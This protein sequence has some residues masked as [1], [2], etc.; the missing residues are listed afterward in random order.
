MI[1]STWDWN[2]WNGSRKGK[3]I[4]FRHPHAPPP[5]SPPLQLKFRR[6]ISYVLARPR[7]GYDLS[8]YISLEITKADSFTLTRPTYIFREPQTG[9][10]EESIR[11]NFF[12][13]SRQDHYDREIWSIF[14][15]FQNR[16]GSS[17]ANLLSRSCFVAS[18]NVNEEIVDE[19]QF[20]RRKRKESLREFFESKAKFRIHQ[21]YVKAL[22]VPLN[23]C[24]VLFIGGGRV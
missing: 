6:T 15:R 17:A 13:M 5:P 7:R 21:F 8:I 23:L 16:F 12:R 18:S 14:S 2:C 4:R 10:A 11:A 20:K 24:N 22:Q 19:F 3:N 9:F 1:Q